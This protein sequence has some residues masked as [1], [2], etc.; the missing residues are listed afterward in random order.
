VINDL[1]RVLNNPEEELF[2]E[3]NRLLET[4]KVLDK[5]LLESN[6][7]LLHYEARELLI[8]HKIQ[9]DIVIIIAAFSDRPVQELQNLAR[10]ITEQEDRSLIFLM[11]RIGNDYK[12]VCARGKIPKVNMKIIA[13]KSLLLIN[14]KGGGNEA[15]AQGGG[16][17][18]LN[19][20][21]F[22]LEV[23]DIIGQQVLESR[24]F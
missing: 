12:I 7:K 18:I 1:T 20:V 15:F 2:S 13:Q 16:A 19:E 4:I 11:A 3:V 10:I 24:S 22:I 14:G 8:K 6:E 17:A 23:T 5:T 9:D 21:E